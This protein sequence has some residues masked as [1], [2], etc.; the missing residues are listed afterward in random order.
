M[1]GGSAAKLAARSIFAESAGWCVVLVT[2]G[3][4]YLR[5]GALPLVSS[6]GLGLADR[7][8]ELGRRGY[9]GRFS[10]VQEQGFLGV[11]PLTLTGPCCQRASHGRMN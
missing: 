1:V 9:Q 3:A 7:G 8:R 2:L 11:H 4:R 5:L 10:D 6:G